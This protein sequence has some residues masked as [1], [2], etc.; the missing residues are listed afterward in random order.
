MCGSATRF[1]LGHRGIWGSAPENGR[2]QNREDSLSEGRRPSAHQTAEPN[3]RTAD[4][5]VPLAP[6]S[7]LGRFFD[8][9][10]LIPV[11]DSHGLFWLNARV[12]LIYQVIS[13][14]S[15][16]G[17][18]SLPHSCFHYFVFK[19]WRKETFNEHSD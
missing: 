13:E 11:L 16:D 3:R 8:A 2:S 18:A 7:R 19:T 4:T 14:L 6:R 15:L 1:R 9:N 12:L 10:W 17:I 5:I